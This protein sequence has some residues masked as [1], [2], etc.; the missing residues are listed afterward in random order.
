MKDVKFSL[1]GRTPVITVAGHIDHGKTTFLNFISKN[2]NPQKEHGGITQHIKP[3]YINTKHGYMTFLDTPGHFAFN[4]N[5]ENCIKVSDLVLLIISIDDGI[6]PQTIETINIA[7]KF[8]ITIIV[9]INKIDKFEN[10]DDK[11]EKI[12]N[13]LL[14]YGLTAEKW[15]GD[16]IVT[17]ISSKTGLGIDKLIDSIKLQTD[18]LDVKLDLYSNPE[19]IILE[20]RLDKG[21]GVVTTLILKNGILE[22]GCSISINKNIY[23]I[24]N[25]YDIDKNLIKKAYPSLPVEV[26]G[27]D[28]NFE[29]GAIFK[30]FDSKIK[31]LNKVTLVEKSINEDTNIYNAQSLIEDMK[32][33]ISKKLNLII[34]VDVQGSIIVV[35]NLIK[36][37]STDTIKINIIKIGIGSFNDSD[38]DLAV[39]TNAILIGFNIKIENNIKQLFVKNKI[40]YYIFNIIYDLFNL[41]KEKVLKLTVLE[42]T[43]DILGSAE[44]KKI[45]I[46]KD[47]CIAG[48]LVT[49]GKIK[50]NSK[51][52]IRRND[53]VIYEGIIES[54]KIHKN[55]TKEV[56]SGIECGISIKKYNDLSIKDIID[57]Y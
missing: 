42:N 4:S 46:Y 33:N 19:G 16:L 54:I 40:E 34:K 21:K 57:V 17:T 52:K 48:C 50:I 29:I 9:A 13:E 14:S 37:L 36:S 1:V 51:I 7:K 49:F 35:Q 28:T 47:K 6:K 3:Y 31:G 22:R 15:G 56:L 26:T 25:I 5:R 45:F 27:L 39:I 10:I 24:K 18:I 41:L 30:F 44:V 8:N 12:L 20:N 23:K 53:K 43:L 11:K 32:K 38:I 2:K 55:M